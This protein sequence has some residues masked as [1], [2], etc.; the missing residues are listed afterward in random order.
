MEILENIHREMVSGKLTDVTVTCKD[1]TTTA[2]RLVL[3]AHSPYFQGMFSSEA[4]TG[5]LELPSVSLSVFQDILKACLCGGNPLNEDNWME[6]L[7]AAEMMQLP[8]IKQLCIVYL[9]K[10]L[11]FTPDNCLKLWRTLKMYTLLDFAKRAFS[12]MSCNITDFLQTENLVQVS[13]EE[14]LGILTNDDLTCKETYILKA[15]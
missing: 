7:D 14:R 1:G 11:L 13:K 9:D 6:F 3:A 12:F 5:I 4:R 10:H 15:V 8:H 2:S